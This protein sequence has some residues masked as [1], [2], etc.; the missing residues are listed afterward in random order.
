MSEL[1]LWIAVLGRAIDDLYFERP[2]CFALLSDYQKQ[3][4]EQQQYW[5]RTARAWIKSKDT[6]CFNNFENICLIT[7]FDAE[8]LREKLYNLGLL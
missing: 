4:I 8:A 2:K 1:D 6:S 7:G 3:K 5:K